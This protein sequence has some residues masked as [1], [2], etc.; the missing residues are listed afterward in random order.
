MINV[1]QTLPYG[2]VDWQLY[3]GELQS[4]WERMFPPDSTDWWAVGQPTCAVQY[5]RWMKMD[6]CTEIIEPSLTC[7]YPGPP[8]PEGPTGPQG[9]PGEGVGIP[10]PTGPT[11]PAGPTG[12]QGPP[13]IQGEQGESGLGGPQGEPGETGPEGP[14]G[15][16]GP[17]G[18][19]G[20]GGPQGPTGPTGATGPVG[21]A[22]GDVYGNFDGPLQVRGL[23]NV[24]IGNATPPTSA[25]ALMGLT[26]GQQGQWG[27]RAVVSSL[28]AGV[29]MNVAP[30][31]SN[32]NVLINCSLPSTFAA[33]A[34]DQALTSAGPTVILTSG[35]IASGRLFLITATVT[36]SNTT[37]T[38]GTVDIW[39]Q[40]PTAATWF[41][42]TSVTVV[43]NSLAT[44]SLSAI[45]VNTAGSAAWQIWGQGPVG[46]ICRYASQVTGR[47]N[48]TTM[49][50]LQIA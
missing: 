27:P 23:Y 40:D 34:A 33:L 24:P 44:V 4:L 48:A 2:E 16:Q 1:L 7:P 46:M 5:Y 12:P 18:G 8:G 26:G 22:Q 36:I 13:G 15:P 45:R 42:V 39:L 20:P 49:A 43:A 37:G 10:G 41:A 47:G 9:D 19:Q 35:S 6:P 30:P 11:G 3:S 14:A 25:Q 21:S 29:G 28:V 50:T 38:T 32:G 31:D 17:I